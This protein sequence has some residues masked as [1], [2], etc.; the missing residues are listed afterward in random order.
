ML[1]HAWLGHSFDNFGHP[2]YD[3]EA[4]HHPS[5]RSAYPL[6]AALTELP[7]TLPGLAGGH[8]ARIS[9][10]AEVQEKHTGKQHGLRED[11][12]VLIL[13]FS[14]LP[15]HIK[16]CGVDLG[17]G[18]GLAIQLNISYLGSYSLGP[19]QVLPGSESRP[20]SSVMAQI[21]NPSTQGLRQEDVKL[22][23]MLYYIAKLRIKKQ[24]AN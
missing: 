12:G 15:K 17:T 23:T 19:L 3:T 13:L 2:T 1:G 14:A 5:L 11:C 10:C 21:C 7:G 4:G 9:R 8:K 24:K 20:E 6:K 18:P 22:E 16:C